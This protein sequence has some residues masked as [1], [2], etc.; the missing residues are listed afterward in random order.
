MLSIPLCW[1]IAGL[2]WAGFS[3]AICKVQHVFREANRVAAALAK[4]GCYM[5]ENFVIMDS[6]PYDVVSNFVYLDATRENFCRL[7]ASN[8][9]I[10]A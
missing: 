3:I 2:F 1:L 5:Q 4:L 10:L 7:T 6:F 9:A 8:L